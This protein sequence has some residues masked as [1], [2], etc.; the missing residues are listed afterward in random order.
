M[1]N[2]RGILMFVFELLPLKDRRRIERR[3]GGLKRKR[4]CR[5]HRLCVIQ[6]RPTPFFFLCVKYIS[7][8]FAFDNVCLFVCEI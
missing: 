2:E 4:K 1:K 3:G 5:T 7:L 6:G 8:L